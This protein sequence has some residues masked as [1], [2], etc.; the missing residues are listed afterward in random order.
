[1]TIFIIAVLAIA[2]IALIV[3]NTKAEILDFV[4]EYKGLV[5]SVFTAECKD[6]FVS[7]MKHIGKSL[8]KSLAN[9]GRVLKL[10]GFWLL[11]PLTI[12]LIPVIAVG[13]MTYRAFI[14]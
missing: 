6:E 7:D 13:V 3:K 5:K 2:L 4:Q 8:V 9:I 1:M 11:L 14:K 10:L 12:V